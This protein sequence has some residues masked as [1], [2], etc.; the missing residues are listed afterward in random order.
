MATTGVDGGGV[1][2]HSLLY[3]RYILFQLSKEIFV[4]V[5][6]NELHTADDEVV[7]S[8]SCDDIHLTHRRYIDRL[9]ALRWLYRP[10][11][12]SQAKAVYQ[13]TVLKIVTN[14]IVTPGTTMTI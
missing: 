6:T 14:V 3:A 4:K 9:T 8:V 11:D 1:H 10:I 12:Q 13:H 7:K 5:C 2:H